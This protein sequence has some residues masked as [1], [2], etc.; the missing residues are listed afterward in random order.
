VN[1]FL[2]DRIR[3]IRGETDIEGRVDGIKLKHGEIERVSIEHLDN[4]LFMA[5]GWRFVQEIDEISE[6]DDA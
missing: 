4:W 5:D 6:E 1:I 2:G 3:M